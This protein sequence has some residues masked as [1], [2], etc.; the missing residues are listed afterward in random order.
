MGAQHDRGMGVEEMQPGRHALD[1]ADTLLIDRSFDN[2]TIR[3]IHI[4]FV[5]D[6][7]PLSG[8][9]PLFAEEPQSRK[10]GFDV[11]KCFGPLDLSA[12]PFAA[13]PEMYFPPAV[14]APTFPPRDRS[15]D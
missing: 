2:L 15:Q 4:P 9:V 13:S 7:F 11:L 12:D 6:R 10:G 5:R 14:A 1:A 8:N 3:Q